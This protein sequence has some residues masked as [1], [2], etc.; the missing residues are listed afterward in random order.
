M[1]TDERPPDA[2][3]AVWQMLFSRGPKSPPSNGKDFGMAL[4]MNFTTAKPAIACVLISYEKRLGN[5]AQ[6]TPNRLAVKVHPVFRPRYTFEAFT[7]APQQRPTKTARMVMII[8]PSSGR[9]SNGLKGSIVK[10]S[11]CSI[12]KDLT[13]STSRSFSSVGYALAGVLKVFSFSVFAGL[14]SVSH[15]TS[16]EEG[17]EQVAQSSTRP[18]IKVKLTLWD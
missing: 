1:N 15:E 14:S 11:W 10:S 16:G 3:A 8:L 18:Q 5:L 13:R 9:S 12:S 17:V 7:R 2:M 4:E 6:P